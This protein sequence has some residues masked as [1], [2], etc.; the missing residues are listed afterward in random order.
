MY[1]NTSNS[2]YN[3]YIYILMKNIHHVSKEFEMF[4]IKYIINIL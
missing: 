1:S 2:I 4:A 3:I